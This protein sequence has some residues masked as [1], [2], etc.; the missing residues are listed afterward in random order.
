MKIEQVSGWVVALSALWIGCSFAYV[1]GLFSGQPAMLT[2]LVSLEQTM[3]A[4]SFSVGYLLL[5]V[6]PTVIMMENYIQKPIIIMMNG[7]KEFTILMNLIVGI[8]IVIVATFEDVYSISNTVIFAIIVM[9]YL[10]LGAAIAIMLSV[11]TKMPQL[12]YIALFPVML[13]ASYIFG[14]A[15]VDRGPDDIE[16]TLKSAGVRCGRLIF[17]S[18]DGVFLRSGNNKLIYISSEDYSELRESK[19][20]ARAASPPA[21]PP[22][23]G[24]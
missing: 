3:S 5:I 21:A 19:C 6:G 8:L 12:K 22:N 14:V 9:L 1:A 23:P 16:V 15:E 2:G 10:G 4:S 20:K 13:G 7:E 11:R 24:H 18:K 17:V